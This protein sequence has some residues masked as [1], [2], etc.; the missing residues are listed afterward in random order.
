MRFK[1]GFSNGFEPGD[2]EDQWRGYYLIKKDKKNHF[3]F[4]VILLA[5]VGGGLK[6][7]KNFFWL[8]FPP[9]H[10][11]EMETSRLFS[12][13]SFFFLS[14]FFSFWGSET[15]SVATQKHLVT[16]FVIIRFF[17]FIA[18]AAILEQQTKIK[19]KKG[20]KKREREGMDKKKRNQIRIFFSPSKKIK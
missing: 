6:K 11:R 1:N 5:L 20:V 2:D 4:F 8:K 16:A 3:V 19:K 10:G 13:H 9:R 17:S 12:A 14:L 18:T 15:I 7:K